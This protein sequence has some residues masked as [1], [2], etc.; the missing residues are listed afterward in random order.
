MKKNLAVI[1]LLIG[2]VT[3]CAN[4]NLASSVDDKAAKQF[5]VPKGK[6]VIYTVQNGGYLPGWN[7]FQVIVDG[8]SKGSLAA[9]TYHRIVVEP[10]AHTV[11]A[12]SPENE[13]GI[14]L[15]TEPG[16]VYFLS[17]TSYIGMSNM[18][19]T[20]KSLSESIGKEAVISA[21]LAKGLIFSE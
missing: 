21:T 4:V 19:V 16:N 6:S 3:G 17:L 12:S 2:V 9:H 13:E 1:T 18:K 15:N 7:T 11:I 14:K 10:G 20:L 5:Y 8:Q